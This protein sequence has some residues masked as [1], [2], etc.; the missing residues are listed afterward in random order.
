MPVHQ[1]LQY[2]VNVLGPISVAGPEGELDPGGTKPRLLL[3]LLVANTGT[4]VPTERLIDGLW[5]ED[6]PATARKTVH[7]HV[8]NLRRSLGAGFPLE[9]TRAGYRIV[10][11]Q[12]TIDAVRFESGLGRGTALIEPSPAEA[13]DVL[14]AALQLWS[15]PAYADVADEEAIRPETLR[16]TELRISAIE[17]R[18]EADLRV[19]RHA[20]LLGELETLTIDNPFRERLRELQML[21]LYRCGRQADAL[22]TYDRTRRTLAEELGV[23][24]GPALR[25]LYQ[26]I[27]EQSDDLHQAIGVATPTN[28]GS[29]LLA[30]GGRTIRGYELR[31]RVGRHGDGC[32]LRPSTEFT[33]AQ[34]MV[35][36]SIDAALTANRGPEFTQAHDRVQESIDAALAARHSTDLTRSQVLVQDAIDAALASS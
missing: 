32:P 4:M 14:A 24:P 11:D 17:H 34:E 1:E 22:R 20:A 29:R 13:A 26:R 16:L 2:Q 7:V 5:G 9:T 12:L 35:Q 23:D 27:L 6:P 18:I 25:Q 10:S 15:G 31:E 3:S 21:A 19:G 28:V 33:R 8:S 36:D 30:S